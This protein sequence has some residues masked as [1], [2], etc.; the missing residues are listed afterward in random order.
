MSWAA[1]SWPDPEWQRRAACAAEEDP[2]FF[3]SAD[4]SL[5]VRL[6]EADAVAAQFCR[7]CPVAREC[8]QYA[9]DANIEIGVWGGAYRHR[10]RL[11][12]TITPLPSMRSVGAA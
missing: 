1:V 3:P 11:K 6:G 8:A 9:A 12:H 2:R 4:Q 5:P 7:G 10:Y